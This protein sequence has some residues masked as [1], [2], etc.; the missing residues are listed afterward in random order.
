MKE[1]S[2]FGEGSIHSGV[3]GGVDEVRGG[4]MCRVNGGGG[5]DVVP[6]GG[7]LVEFEGGEGV[8]NETF[9]V[10][11]QVRDIGNSTFGEAEEV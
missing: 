2:G 3:D 9:R 11:V 4:A 1:A 7:P 10:G 5:R 8:V 6:E